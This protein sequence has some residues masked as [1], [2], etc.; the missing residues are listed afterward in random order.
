M[1]MA[2][3][4]R[5]S[6]QL[7]LCPQQGEQQQLQQREQQQQPQFH[8]FL[9][10]RQNCSTALRRQLYMGGE[11]QQ[12][13]QRFCCCSAAAPALL[14]VGPGLS[15][16]SG[17]PFQLWQQQQQRQ[18]LLLRPRAPAAAAAAAAAD[19]KEPCCCSESPTPCPAASQPDSSALASAAATAAAMPAALQQQHGQA[20]A[21]AAVAAATPQPPQLQL[22]LQQEL[23]GVQQLQQLQLQQL[24]LQRGKDLKKQQEQQQQQQQGQQQQQQQQQEGDR[25]ILHLEPGAGSKLQQQ[26]ASLRAAAAAAFG[27]DDSFCYLLHCSVSGYFRCTDIAAVE[28]HVAAAVKQLQQEQQQH[29]GQQ[30]QQQQQQQEGGLRCEGTPRA[31]AT[32]DGHVLLP[33][34][35]PVLLPLVQQLQQQLQQQQLCCLRLKQMDHITLAAAREDPKVRRTIQDFY[36]RGLS[37]EEV[38]GGPWDL[39]LYRLVH[40]SSSFAAGG[41]HRFFQVQRY[42]G[43]ASGF[44]SFV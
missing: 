10:N 39:V 41:P 9:C 37:K 31:M 1:S 2:S 14:H 32:D 24:H 44:V 3:G 34:Q 13:Q 38:G 29:H 25:Y 27:C 17:P 8:S 15:L 11:Q 42:P 16:F 18:Q 21:A 30:Q 36:N 43:A 26:L 20:A 23:G 40:F 7:Q 35:C 4:V 5:A 28:A 22:N 6:Q 33:L 12:Q 19:D